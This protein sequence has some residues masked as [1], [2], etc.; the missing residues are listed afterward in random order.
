MYFND[1]IMCKFYVNQFGLCKCDKFY[2]GGCQLKVSVASF[3]GCITSS[4][5]VATKSSVAIASLY[6]WR[7]AKTKRAPD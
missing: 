6:N 1:V 5:I 2:R 4:N 7:N 3:I